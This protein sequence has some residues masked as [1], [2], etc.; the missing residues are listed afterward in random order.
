MQNIHY[1][2]LSA[3]IIHLKLI[4]RKQ[5]FKDCV[6]TSCSDCLSTDDK[7]WYCYRDEEVTQS[8]LFGQTINEYRTIKALFYV[9]SSN[10]PRND[11]RFIDRVIWHS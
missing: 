8:Y 1:M 10:F 11:S 5:N 7:K 3:T 6:I 9:K 4:Q 2:G